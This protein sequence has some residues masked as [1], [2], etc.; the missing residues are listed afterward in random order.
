MR[1]FWSAAFILFCI[2]NTRADSNIKYKYIYI[3]LSKR[4]VRSDKIHQF[5][6]N[7]V[8]P[9]RALLF[10]RPLASISIPFRVQK[11]TSNPKSLFLSNLVASIALRF[12]QFIHL[13]IQLSKYQLASFRARSRR[14]K[15]ANSVRDKLRDCTFSIRPMPKLRP[16]RECSLNLPARRR[17][18]LGPPNEREKPLRGPEKARSN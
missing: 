18:R 15:A 14:V 2:A 11:G 13:F 9:V 4:P 8:G 6:A 10:C 5:H 7:A 1:D 12:S 17:P 16:A 3:Y